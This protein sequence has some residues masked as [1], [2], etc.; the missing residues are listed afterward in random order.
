MAS[1]IGV[2]VAEQFAN[3][4]QQRHA[5]KLGMWAWLLTELLLFAGLLGAALVIRTLHP[6]SVAAAA[7]HLKLWIGAVNSVILIFSSLAMTGAIEMSK[8]G[9]GRLVVRCLLGTAAL[10]LLF[11]CLKSYEYYDDYTEHMTPFLSRPYALA[12]DRPS[13]LFVNLYWT[14]TIL[15]F[16][17]LSVGVS[18]VLVMAWL[19]SRPYFFER[20]QNRIEIVG[21]YWHF[22]D[23]VWLIVFPT[24][25]MANR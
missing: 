19:A 5:A 25:Y 8:Q 16:I 24:L 20:H 23:L 7:S 4:A 14:T 21:L 10:G 13:I 22:I 17:H 12:G 11:L 1:T 18:I 9:R 3:E 2:I 6:A 15:H